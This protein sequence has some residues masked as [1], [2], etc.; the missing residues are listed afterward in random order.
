M[1]EEVLGSRHSVLADLKVA[2][3]PEHNALVLSGTTEQI[4]EALDLVARL[5]IRPAR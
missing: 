4:R 2:A 5:D 1:V 3:Q